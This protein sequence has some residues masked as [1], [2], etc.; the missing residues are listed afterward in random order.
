MIMNRLFMIV[1]SGCHPL[2]TPL[3]RKAGGQG[4]LKGRGA[5][6]VKLFQQSEVQ[7]SLVK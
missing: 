2:P 6:A 7:N 5:L 3:A 4:A 1:I